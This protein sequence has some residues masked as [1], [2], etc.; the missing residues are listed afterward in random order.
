MPRPPR[1]RCQGCVCG[2]AMAV[3]PRRESRALRSNLKPRATL[4]RR[5]L[6][7]GPKHTGLC[8]RG[9]A[10]LSLMPCPARS[11]SCA[12]GAHTARQEGPADTWRHKH[13]RQGRALVC[14]PTNPTTGILA[15]F[16]EETPAPQSSTKAA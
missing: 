4:L 6:Y 16:C 10:Q 2:V 12:Y 3:V 5:C 15:G 14:G 13:H 1:L 7:A 11:A 8:P 9:P